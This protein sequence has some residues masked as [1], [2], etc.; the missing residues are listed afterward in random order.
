MDQNVYD[1]VIRYPD[2]EVETRSN[3]GRTDAVELMRS[4]FRG[5]ELDEV[6][7]QVHKKIP[8]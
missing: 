3:I 5:M 8:S 2:G 1:I 4:L 7:V 6:T